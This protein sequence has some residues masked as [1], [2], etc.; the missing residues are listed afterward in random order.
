MR[1][2][3]P[4]RS[5]PRRQPRPTARLRLERLE[6][7]TAPAVVNWTL[8]A[9]GDFADPNNWTVAGA[10]PPQHSVPGPADDAVIPASFAVT[11][12]AN[13]TVNS[14]LATNFSILAGTFTV[15]AQATASALNGLVLFSGAALSVA[16]GNQTVFVTSSTI[17]GAL[18]VGSGSA[19]A[20]VGGTNRLGTGT[21]V[22]GAGQ[23]LVTGG[24]LVVNAPVSVANFNLFAGTLGGTGALTLTG[25]ST[26]S[27]GTMGDAGTTTV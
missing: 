26:W 27:G 9:N 18:T 1:P 23:V 10:S 16:S 14:L 20:F 25:T 2:T 11:S 13:Q 4:P 5:R 24:A 22:S 7:R 17:S 8:G 6:D 15:N 21:T 19:L 3:A 12:S